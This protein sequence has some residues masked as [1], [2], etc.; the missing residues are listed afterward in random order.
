VPPTFIRVNHQDHKDHRERQGKCRA[1][2]KGQGPRAQGN[3]VTRYRKEVFTTETTKTTK[4]FKD[5]CRA[6][7]RAAN[8][9]RQ[10]LS[11]LLLSCFPAIFLFLSCSPTSPL[12]TPCIAYRTAVCYTSRMHAR[13]QSTLGA[14]VFNRH[15][16]LD[17]PVADGLGI[18]SPWTGFQNRKLK[19][20]GSPKPK[21]AA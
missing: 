4:K 14:P 11:D 18:I 8:F 9:T 20:G 12:T 6:L 13:E 17:T 19:E 21:K 16:A 2:S 3:T 15:S 7:P 5:A 10:R 1:R